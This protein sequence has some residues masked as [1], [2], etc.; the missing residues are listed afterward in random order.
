[1]QKTLNIY[2]RGYLNAKAKSNG[3]PTV[4]DFLR[5]S[6]GKI[7][8]KEMADK[9]TVST[10]AIRRWAVKL[11]L[12]IR[13]PGGSKRKPESTIALGDKCEKC[14]SDEWY[15]TSKKCAPCQRRACARWYKRRKATQG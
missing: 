11:D 8:T 9:L 6:W 14:G 5:G 15:K 12:P 4:E 7:T 1:M 3:Y 13:K 10:T 2:H